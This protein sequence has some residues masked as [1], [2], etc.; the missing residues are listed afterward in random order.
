LL[1]GFD[2]VQYPDWQALL[3]R[4]WA[5]ARP[6]SVLVLDEFPSMVAAAREL[7]SVIQKILDLNAT[8]RVHL[9]IAGSSQRMM[10]GLVLD[11]TA[12][13][14]GRTHEILEIGPLRAGWIQ[15]AL[16]LKDGVSAVESYSVW[17]GIPRYWELAATCPNLTRAVRDLVLSPLGVLHDEPAGLLL[18]DLRDTAQATSILSLVG[19]GCHRMSEIAARLEKPATS[20]SR[21]LQRLVDLGLV[22]RETPFGTSVRDTKRTAYRLGDPF[23]RFWFRFVGPN[24]SRLATRRLEPVEREVQAAF[25][26]HVGSVW[27]DLAR[28]SVPS[29][30]DKREW[31]P[32]SR[33]WGPGLDRRPMEIDVVAESADGDAVLVG[34]VRWSA[35]DVERVLAELRRKADNLPLAKG[36]RTVLAVWSKSKGRRVGSARTIG[37]EEVIRRLL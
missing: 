33:W 27:E 22:R 1:P 10:H 14:Y 19:G 28:E 34:E 30:G 32:A 4:F 3:A 35:I 25:A 23:L 16:Q 20:L 7:P 15:P 24:R 37:P 13:L 18:D 2:A 9:V 8:K 17:G 12:P 26:H 36:R 5:E 11:Q 31:G 6:G 21:P 29:L